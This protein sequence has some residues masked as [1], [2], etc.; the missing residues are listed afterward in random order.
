MVRRIDYSDPS[1]IADARRKLAEMYAKADTRGRTEI[2]R[3]LGYSGKPANIRRSV[4]R[5]SRFSLGPGEM[6]N[7]NAYFRSYV[8]ESDPE[9]W[10]RLPVYHPLPP[11]TIRGKAQITA[12]VMVLEM[13]T[14]EGGVFF[15]TRTGWLNTNAYDSLQA[16]FDDFNRRPQDMFED[17]KEYIGVEAIAFSVEGIDAL[18]SLPQ[19]DTA[20]RPKEDPD[21][22]GITL[23]STVHQWRDE[24]VE[25]KKKT[26]HLPLTPPTAT[27]RPFPTRPKGRREKMIRYIRLAHPQRVK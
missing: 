22:Y 9:P 27:G 23:H 1:V 19:Y 14:Y 13:H 24:I 15:D 25:G 11:Y 18:L 2:G 26:V 10:K 12:F 4:R 6:D 21:N 20:I 3:K 5:I 8:L 16:V 7:V 17:E